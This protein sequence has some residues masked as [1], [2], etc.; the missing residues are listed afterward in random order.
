MVL[1]LDSFLLEHGP[2]INAQTENGWTPLHWASFKGALEVVRLLLEYFA[3]VEVKN[4]DVKTAFQVAT[5]G[6]LEKV[7]ELLRE[8]GAK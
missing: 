4:K 3:D 5:D 1:S 6:G 7:V 8:H 2:D